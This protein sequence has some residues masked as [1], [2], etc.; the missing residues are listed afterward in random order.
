ME[1]QPFLFVSCV[2]KAT[3]QLLSVSEYIWHEC[4]YL[5]FKFLKKKSWGVHNCTNLSK[6]SVLCTQNYQKKGKKLSILYEK[7]KYRSKVG[8]LDKYNLP[9]CRWPGANSLIMPLIWNQNIKIRSSYIHIRSFSL[10]KV[11]PKSVVFIFGGG[12]NLLL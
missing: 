11:C 12:V 8:L 2:Q 3:I 9:I 6:C 4:N 7:L 1:C 10:K 5:F